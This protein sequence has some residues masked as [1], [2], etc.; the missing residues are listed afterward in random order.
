MNIGGAQSTSVVPT[1]FFKCHSMMSFIKK[2]LSEIISFWSRKKSLILRWLPR[3]ST[4][5][6]IQTGKTC[7]RSPS[8]VVLQ[9]LFLNFTSKVTN[10]I[11][12]IFQVLLLRHRLLSW[13]QNI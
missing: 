5:V 11:T 3:V 1:I 10:V 13:Q 4:K 9:S 12:L 6:T 7:K 8:S 2:I